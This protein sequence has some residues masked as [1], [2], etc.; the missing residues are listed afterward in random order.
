MAFLDKVMGYGDVSE[1][2]NNDYVTE[3]FFEDEKVIQSYQFLRDQII[4][5]NY[6]I[7]E[8]NVQGLSGKKV[9]VKFF[10]K[11]TIRTISFETAGVIDFDVDIKIGVTNNTVVNENGAAYS[12]PISFKVPSNQAKEAK[13]VVRLV[14]KHYLF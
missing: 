6:G 13:E 2:I 4:L 3:F 10:P 8:V 9:E 5:T 7:Y 12:E 14:K 1:D 11:E